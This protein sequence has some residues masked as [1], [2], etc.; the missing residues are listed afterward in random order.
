MNSASSEMR[1][2]VSEIPGQD[3]NQKILNYFKPTVYIPTSDDPPNHWCP[4]FVN[5]MFEQNSIRG[6]RTA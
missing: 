4:A 1:A 6:T 2:G 3:N 5:S